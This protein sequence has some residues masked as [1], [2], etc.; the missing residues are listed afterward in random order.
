[1]RINIDEKRGKEVGAGSEE[2]DKR[3]AAL[4]DGER[5]KDM[6]AAERIAERETFRRS[7]ALAAHMIERAARNELRVHDAPRYPSG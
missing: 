5:E 6:E 2:E 3:I 7:V 4:P 1:L